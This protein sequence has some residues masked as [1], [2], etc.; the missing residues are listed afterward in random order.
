MQGYPHNTRFGIIKEAIKEFGFLKTI[1]L[2][3]SGIS[4]RRRYGEP[5]SSNTVDT[6]TE[7][8]INNQSDNAAS[9]HASNTPGPRFG[10]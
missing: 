5:G 8:D 2:V 1:H 4:S 6:D 10:H 3:L 9:S 7:D